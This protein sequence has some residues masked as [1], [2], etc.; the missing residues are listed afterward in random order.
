MVPGGLGGVAGGAVLLHLRET[1][2]TFLGVISFLIALI[3]LILQLTI[4]NILYDYFYVYFFQV[5]FSFTRSQ[6]AFTELFRII[7]ELVDRSDYN[8]LSTY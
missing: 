8:Y 5:G 6:A 7:T 2:C 4:V 3:V 1:D